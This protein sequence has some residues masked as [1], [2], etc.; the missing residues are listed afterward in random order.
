MVAASERNQWHE[1]GLKTV[2]TII[3]EINFRKVEI[4]VN[5]VVCVRLKIFRIASNKKQK[6]SFIYDLLHVV[7]AILLPGN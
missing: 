3:I 5:S 1:N 2:K 7:S 4:E 6:F